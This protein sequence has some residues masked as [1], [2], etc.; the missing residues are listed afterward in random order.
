MDQRCTKDCRSAKC[1]CYSRNDLQFYFRIFFS[2]FIHQSGHTIDS[3]ITTADHGNPFAFHSLFKS[4]HTSVHFFFHWC[5]QIFF[6]WKCIFDK[7]HIYRI[8]NNRITVFQSIHCNT[9]HLITAPRSDSNYIYFIQNEPP[10]SG[11]QARLSRHF[12]LSY[13]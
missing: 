4:Q 8:S 6:I 3:G 13:F 9:G 5:G 12:S 10:S 1:G 2:Y 11:V 7:I